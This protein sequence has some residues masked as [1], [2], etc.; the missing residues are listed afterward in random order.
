[1]Y[2]YIYACVY[3]YVI[4]MYYYI[5]IYIYLYIIMFTCVCD[6]ESIR[7]NREI[8]SAIQKP[9][10]GASSDTYSKKSFHIFTFSR[11]TL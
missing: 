3:V 4:Y 7:P 9:V 11:R 1:M 8:T 6:L 2:I 5:I 10:T